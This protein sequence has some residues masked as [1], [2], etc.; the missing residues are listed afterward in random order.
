MPETPPS[1]LLAVTSAICRWSRTRNAKPW[2]P[3]RFGSS[4]K[5]TSSD[6]HLDWSPDHIKVINK[7]EEA[8]VR[9]G[10]FSLAMARV[11]QEFT[12]EVACIWA[13]LN[14]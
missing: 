9:G 1:H 11:W 4:A 13:V 12:P 5:R 14:G 6:F 8:V 2:P 3:V 7:I 10:L